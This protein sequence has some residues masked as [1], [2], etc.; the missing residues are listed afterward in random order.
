MSDYFSCLT[1]PIPQ[2]QNEL[3]P[4]LS[5]IC[6]NLGWRALCN[7]PGANST[8]LTRKLRHYPIQTKILGRTRVEG[9]DNRSKNVIWF[10]RERKKE[11]GLDVLGGV[12]RIGRCSMSLL[13]AHVTIHPVDS[14][15]GIRHCRPSRGEKHFGCNART[16]GCWN[17]DPTRCWICRS[18]I[19]Q[20]KAFGN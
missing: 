5:Y 10:K 9:I 20:L 6:M 4:R 15:R 18:T 7:L 1:L 16:Y 8:K 12:K 13:R 19:D 2:Q 17:S 14:H 3:A 11:K